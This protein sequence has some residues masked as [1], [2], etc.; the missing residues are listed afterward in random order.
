MT[1]YNLIDEEWIPVLTRTGEQRALGIREILTNSSEILTI[2]AELPTIS[3][4]I[5]RLLQAVLLRAAGE[6]PASVDARAEIWGRWWED[7]QFPAA[8]VDAYL[9]KWHNRFDL[10]DERLP[11]F[12]VP[13]LQLASGKGSGL[14]KLMADVPAGSRL[15][16]TRSGDAIER[17]SYAEAA[18]WLVHTQAF[19][20]RGIKSGAT[21]DARVNKGKSYSLRYPAWAGNLGIISLTGSDLAK[22]LLLNLT[23]SAT[24]AEDHPAW[25]TAPQRIASDGIYS[26]PQGAAQVWTWPSRM[27]RL[28]EHGGEVIDAVISNGEALGPQNRFNVEPMT[29]WRH[30]EP[31]TKKLGQATY[32]PVPHQP[33]R[34][35]WRGLQ[36]ILAQS[37][38]GEETRARPALSLEWLGRLQ[39]HGHLSES[40]PVAVRCVAMI[41]GSN[42]ST[43]A[44]DFDDVIPATVAAL[45]KS[46]L[47]RAAVDAVNA[48]RAAVN[49]LRSLARNVALAAG[50]SGDDVSDKAD[51]IELPAWD[52]LRP[53]FERWLAT[54]TPDTTTEDAETAWQHTTAR[55]VRGVAEEHLRMA[56]SAAV[57]GRSVTLRNGET[58]L[59]LGLAGLWFNAALKKALPL[60][61]PAATKEDTHDVTLAHS[62]H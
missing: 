13:E 28:I 60:A 14:H 32:M 20:C 47:R 29:S 18:Q 36:G 35:A 44:Q 54:L 3:I 31:Q 52:A 57:F 15:F 6:L 22:T 62:T 43:F 48:S 59:D 4:S 16:V 11:F 8:D 19:D 33:E 49:A 41:Y 9:R 37:P 50:D 51:A 45:T 2:A 1:S 56:P 55:V 26:A 12:Q 46:R 53:H 40:M 21:G 39:V 58:H 23:L 7:G 27:I 25:E 24:S 10:F 17:L 61:H 5:Q 30:S 34:A 38:S 42:Q